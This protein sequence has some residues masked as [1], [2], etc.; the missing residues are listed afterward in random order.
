[1][2]QPAPTVEVSA[3]EKALSALS[4]EAHEIEVAAKVATANGMNETGAMLRQKAVGM[5]HVLT[6]IETLIT[7]EQPS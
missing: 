3:L 4:V 6:S 1:V 2:S 7:N 5:R